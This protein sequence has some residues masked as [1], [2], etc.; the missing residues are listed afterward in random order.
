MR[1]GKIA[2]GWGQALGG[3]GYLLGPRCSSLRAQDPLQPLS[4]PSLEALLG[5]RRRHP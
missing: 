1:K 2:G 5:T 4:L 3:P